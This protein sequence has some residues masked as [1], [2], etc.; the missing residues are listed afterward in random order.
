[1]FH[2]QLPEIAHEKME[3]IRDE[4]INLKMNDDNDEWNQPRRY[5][6]TLL[7]NLTP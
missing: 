4:I 7:V 2:L 3:D 1:M 5:T 6:P